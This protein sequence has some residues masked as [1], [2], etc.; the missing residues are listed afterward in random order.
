MSLAA[1]IGPLDPILIRVVV[2]RGAQIGI[3]KFSSKLSH[4]YLLVIGLEG[5]R[6]SFCAITEPASWKIVW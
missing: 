2:P 5:K 3:S 4:L 1:E 6:S